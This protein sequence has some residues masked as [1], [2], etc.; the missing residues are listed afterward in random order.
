MNVRFT[1]GGQTFEAQATVVSASVGVGMSLAFT[2]IAPRARRILQ[3]WIGEL[4][5]ES[6][7]E[8]EVRSADFAVVELVTEFVRMGLLSETKGNEILQKFQR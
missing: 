5:D 7:L 4:S 3:E 8:P 1:R 2:V 6:A